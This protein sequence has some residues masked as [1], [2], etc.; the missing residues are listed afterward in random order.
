MPWEGGRPPAQDIVRANRDERRKNANPPSLPK[1]PNL[2]PSRMQR[3]VGFSLALSVSKAGRLLLPRLAWGH[4]IRASSLL[5]FYAFALALIQRSMSRIARS[6]GV[7][8]LLMRAL[9]AHQATL[10]GDLQATG[11]RPRRAEAA[12]VVPN[13][14][15]RLVDDITLSSQRF[16][17]ITWVV[18]EGTRLKQDDLVVLLDDRTAHSALAIA[19]EQAQN[20]VEVRYAR[21]ASQLA[22]IGYFRSTS[23]NQKLPGSVTD[24][25][26]G[27]QRL[28]AEKALLQLEQ[29]QHGSAIAQLKLQERSRISQPFKYAAPFDGVVCKVHRKRGE[30]VHEGET[31]A[32]LVDTTHVLVEGWVGLNDVDLIVSGTPVEVSLESDNPSPVALAERG[33]IASIDVKVEPVTRKVRVTAEVTNHA[34]R[35][36]DGLLAQMSIFVEARRR[37]TSRH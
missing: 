14:R 26:L 22:Q 5:Y 31:V 13:C 33:C 19:E 4:T 17:V 29:A 15:I 30:A 18:P 8:L 7:V 10:A 27:E 11:D 32:E 3:K 34:N 37:P 20:D 35:L 6:F 21:K 36:R 16:G 25:A 1:L 9:H 12:I 23:M 24:F 2:T 28:A